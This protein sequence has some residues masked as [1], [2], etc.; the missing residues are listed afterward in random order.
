MRSVAVLLAPCAILLAILH[1]T[2]PHHSLPIAPALSP[3]LLPAAAGPASNDLLAVAIDASGRVIFGANGAGISIF[4]QGTWTT[5]TTAN[6]IS[7]TVHPPCRPAGLASNTVQAIAVAPG[8]RLWFGT[9]CCGVSTH[10]NNAWSTCTAADGPG[11]G[12]AEDIVTAA[13]VD[14]GKG[15]FGTPHTGLS[16]F[17]RD[18][19]PAWHTYTQAGGLA[20]NDVRALDSGNNQLWIGTFGGGLSVF[21]PASG[22]WITYTV[23][24]GL[25][26][27]NV[28]SLAHDGTVRWIGLAPDD[29]HPGG[30]SRF[31]GAT[32]QTFTAAPA[33]LVDNHVNAVAV[34]HNGQVWAGTDAGASVWNGTAWRTY[35]A[36]NTG[37]GLGADRISGIAVAA[38][39]T[40]WFATRGGGASSFN[41]T[42]WVSY[43]TANHLTVIFLPAAYRRTVV[44]VQAR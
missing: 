23:A 7:D 31:D 29:T 32:W 39:N 28:A 14:Y 19:Q 12:P 9:D 25:G 17:H 34:D 26:S 20:N 10:I 13:L 22:L 3:Q 41:G 21:T 8:G 30:L 42:T 35:T 24:N 44:E 16:T 33:G 15:W 5:F 40:I 37:G 11:K 1:Y 18:A 38:D 6:T 4:D 43:K 2:Y 36:A 27:A